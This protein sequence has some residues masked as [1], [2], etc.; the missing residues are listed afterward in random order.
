MTGPQLAHTMP[1][2]LRL[3]CARKCA[4]SSSAGQRKRMR[5]K[6]NSRERRYLA[7]SV[8]P[9][10]APEAMFTEPACPHVR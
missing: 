5:H 4:A 1:I 9:S 6:L 7:L 10:G 8:A 2:R 3:F